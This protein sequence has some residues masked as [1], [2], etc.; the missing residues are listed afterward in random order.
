LYIGRVSIGR[1]VARKFSFLVRAF[2]LSGLEKAISFAIFGLRGGLR[3][4]QMCLLS[5]LALSSQ[6]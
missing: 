3:E 2:F 6:Y 4:L 1:A 5:A